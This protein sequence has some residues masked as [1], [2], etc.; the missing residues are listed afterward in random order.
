MLLNAL[1]KAV[2]YIK[3]IQDVGLFMTMSNSR[4]YASFSGSPLFYVMFP[5]IGVLFTVSAIINGYQFSKAHNKNFDKLFDLTITALCAVLASISLLGAVIAASAG[6][7]FIAGPWLF[8]ASASLALV[9]QLFM[10][11]LQG[12]RAYEANR[13]SAQRMHY[14]QA[15]LNH[16]FTSILL[17]AVI[18]CITFIMLTAAAPLFGTACAAVATALSASSIIWRILPTN[19]KTTIKSGIGLA[20]PT[21]AE[22][23]AAQRNQSQISTS[24]EQEQLLPVLNYP[25]FFSH[26]DYTATINEYSFQEGRQYLLEL[27]AGKLEKLSDLDKSDHIVQK[28]QS[29]N[30]LSFSL[31]NNLCISKSKSLT[32][33][34]LAF[35]SFWMDKGEIEHIVD[36]AVTLQ[37][38]YLPL[39]MAEEQRPTP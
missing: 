19:L 36:A 35:Q 38:K 32:D 8:L 39:I 18:G 23:L 7:V 24:M 10:A 3:E 34:P 33:Y 21:P 31:N 1:K 29:L 25:R 26:N 2:A 22:E 14:I 13:N 17:T 30:Q 37:Q 4:W 27:I 9:S 6:T 16:L 15:A 12:Y 28:I 20:K 5:F 11:A